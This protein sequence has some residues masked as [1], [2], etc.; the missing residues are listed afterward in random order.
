MPNKLFEYLMAGLPILASK[1]DAV[2]ELIARY[3]VGDTVSSLEPEPLA[4]A[5]EEML[6]NPHR[7]AELRANAARATQSDLRWEV[8]SENLVG[9]YQQLANWS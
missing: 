3:D 8:E 7:L 6:S 1:L 2:S 9:M 4:R 5:I